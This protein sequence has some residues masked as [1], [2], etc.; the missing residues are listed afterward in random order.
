MK[1]LKFSLALT[2]LGGVF[3]FGCGDHTNGG[4]TN[5]VAKGD[6]KY[7]GIF[8][9]NETEDFRT[10]YPLNIV[11]IVGGHIGAQVYEGLVKF[12]QKDLTI[13]PGIAWKWDIS[14]SATTFKFHLRKGVVFHDDPCFKDGKGR[15]VTSADIL[16]C[17]NKLCSVSPNNQQ[18]PNTFKDR[19]VGANDYFDATDKGAAPA[20]GV[21]GVTAPDD[22]TVIIKLTHP[23]P[24]FLNILATQGCWIYAKEALDKYGDD[25]RI[26]CVGTGPFKVKTITEGEA[27]ILERNPNYWAIDQFGNKLPYLDRVEFRFI[28]DKRSA[29]KN[30]TWCSVYR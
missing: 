4:D 20:G 3:F 18:Y 28:K 9:M 11:E 8:K 5:L 27:V 24:G 10:L 30:S 22:S 29:I 16:Y 21:S 6:V 25:M 17:F 1:S 7:G 14:D 26:H 2:L 13:M 12:N 19:V 15:E 23:M